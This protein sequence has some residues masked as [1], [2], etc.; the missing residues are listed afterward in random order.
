VINA[1]L[2]P[3]TLGA[4]ALFNNPND[5]GGFLG[6]LMS[7]KVQYKGNT[8]YKFLGYSSMYGV[9]ETQNLNIKF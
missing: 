7:K 1:T 9:N 5:V 6:R 8:T 2:P 4:D 3:V